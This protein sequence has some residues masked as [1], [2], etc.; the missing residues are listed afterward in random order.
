M[1]ALVLALMLVFVAAPVHAGT[2]VE[3]HMHIEKGGAAGPRVALTLDACSGGIDMRILDTLVEN[4]IPATLFLTGIWLNA[5]RAALPFLK[6]HA[7]LFAFENHGAEHL[8]AVIGTEKPYGIAPAGTADAVMAEVSGGAF[9]IT[10]L[11]GSRP[12]W[13]RDATALYSRD[14]MALIEKAGFRIAGFSLNGDAGASFSAAKT[15]EI[16]SGAQDGDV[17][18]SHMNQPKRPAGDGV[19]AGILALKAKG[20]TFVRL[21]QVT[22]IKD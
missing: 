12:G 17:I 15:A 2:L 3:P 21:D 5:N 10:E 11:L 1:R 4:R 8:P 14:A 19:V 13:Y 6:R 22:V 20:F 9:F 18:I 16:I 7:D